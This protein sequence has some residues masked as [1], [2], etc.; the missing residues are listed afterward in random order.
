MVG[1][2]LLVLGFATVFNFN[3]DQD[4]PVKL[5]TQAIPE[6]KAPGDEAPVVHGPDFDS[7]VEVSQRSDAPARRPPPYVVLKNTNLGGMANSIRGLIQISVLE[8]DEDTTD[9]VFWVTYQ[10]VERLVKYEVE[11][12]T[13]TDTGPHER[14]I[15]IPAYAEFGEELKA[16]WE[17]D[18]REVIPAAD[19]DLAYRNLSGRIARAVNGWGRNPQDILVSWN[20]EDHAYK[21]VHK[22]VMELDSIPGILGQAVGTSESLLRP[23]QLLRYEPYRDLFPPA[24]AEVEPMP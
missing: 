2:G 21:I 3:S 15:E 24:P 18:L 6:S 1:V 8:W 9:A 14:L 7:P 23:N 12:A 20:A 4:D 17:H 13:V 22:T 11:S 5:E 10:Q 16:Q 19:F